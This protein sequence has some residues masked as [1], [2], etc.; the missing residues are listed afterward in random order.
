MLG[1]RS[2][3]SVLLEL[4]L[5]EDSVTTDV[6]AEEVTFAAAVVVETAVVEPLIGAMVVPLTTGTDVRMTAVVLTGTQRVGAEVMTAG[7]V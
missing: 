2:P 3:A 6:T 4:V 5:V 7:S 1:I